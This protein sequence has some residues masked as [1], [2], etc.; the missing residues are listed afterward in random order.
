MVKFEY[1]PEFNPDERQQVKLIRLF[2]DLQET[3]K[4]SLKALSIYPKHIGSL[5]D[6]LSK[7]YLEW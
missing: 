1:I 4:I 7:W 6:L 5:E 3:V 2:L